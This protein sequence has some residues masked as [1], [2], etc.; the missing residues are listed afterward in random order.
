MLVAQSTDGP[1]SWWVQFETLAVKG[2]LYKRIRLVAVFRE[3]QTGI[4][5]LVILR[6]PSCIYCNCH[7]YT[8]PSRFALSRA[9]VG[10]PQP[11][12]G[13]TLPYGLACQVTATAY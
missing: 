10:P 11:P 6:R 9:V 1:C 4:P 2:S 13:Y 5:R 3:C 8:C 7:L 12:G